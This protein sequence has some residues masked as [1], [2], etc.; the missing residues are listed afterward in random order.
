MDDIQFQDAATIPDARLSSL[1]APLLEEREVIQALKKLYLHKGR[2]PISTRDFDRWEQRPFNRSK[3]YSV[4]KS[5]QV[6]CERAGLPTIQPQEFKRQ[7]SQEQETTSKPSRLKNKRRSR[8][9][10]LPP[11][12]YLLE[13]FEKVMA[14]FRRPVT[15]DLLR[16][17]NAETRKTISEWHY[18]RRWGGV[19]KLRA[20][21]QQYQAG[22]ITRADI[23][24]ATSTTRTVL[25]TDAPQRISEHTMGVD[26]RGCVS[27]RLVVDGRLFYDQLEL[28]R[29]YD[30]PTTFVVSELCSDSVPDIFIGQAFGVMQAS[31]QHIFLVA[32]SQIGRLK[33]LSQLIHWSTNVWIGVRAGPQLDEDI[34]MLR[35]VE[36]AIRFLIVEPA[37][38]YELPRPNLTNVGLDWVIAGFPNVVPNHT[39]EEWARWLKNYCGDRDIP[40][41]FRGWYGDRELKGEVFEQT[42]RLSK[43]IKQMSAF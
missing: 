15:C 43:A 11:A 8:R 3:I 36:S 28:P 31:P 22:E 6:A 41:Y 42:P 29:S 27:W 18:R 35:S 26:L 25:K 34:Q 39:C 20:L 33:K 10:K 7:P 12:R 1:P 21:V 19:S 24:K 32:S 16:R 14:H 38:S 30:S 40:F 9:R 23:L 5:W 4:Y 17:Y 37:D 13:H 2:V